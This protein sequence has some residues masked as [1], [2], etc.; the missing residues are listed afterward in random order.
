MQPS[1]PAP[2][3][4]AQVG[5]N[6]HPASRQDAADCSRRMVGSEGAFQSSSC[7]S[8]GCSSVKV[9]ARW[10][11]EEVSILILP[12]GRMQPA[13]WAVARWLTPCFNPHP[14]SRQD[15]ARPARE[16]RTTHEVSILILPLGRMQ[17]EHAGD[18][19]DAGQVSILILPLGRMQQSWPNASRPC[20][21]FQS[22]SCLSAG[23]SMAVENCEVCNRR[24]QSSSCLSAG[25]S[26]TAHC[27][28]CG[29]VVVSILILPLGRM[30][31]AFRRDIA[32][33]QRVSILIL[34]L[35]RMQHAFRRDIA[36]Y[37]RVS[38]L[39]LPLGRMQR[40]RVI[41]AP[42]GVSDYTV[43]EPPSIFAVPLGSR[44]NF[45][46]FSPTDA[47]NGGARTCSGRTGAPRSR[48]PIRG[49]SRSISLFTPYAR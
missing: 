24:F 22:S 42:P 47:A 37:Q 13:N 32:R 44:K 45:C 21:T 19:Q 35:G 5:F 2:T 43:R 7:L 12:L 49:A 46:P 39:I 9:G 40:D 16:R 6:P 15:A 28:T 23:C 8:A 14:A 27:T 33:Y 20:S 25:C 10:R 30:Q 31:H 3:H 34:P 26:P 48:Y 11:G 36:R 29:S 38:I 1:T 18:Q 17:R 41:L 4:Q